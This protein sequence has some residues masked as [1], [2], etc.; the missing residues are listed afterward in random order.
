M[1]DPLATLLAA[2]DAA[3]DAMWIATFKRMHFD[4]L[5]RARNRLAA[6][7]APLDVD[8]L[9][10]ALHLDTHDNPRPYAECP[11]TLN[12]WHVKS[13]AAIAAAYAEETP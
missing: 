2:I 10:R 5:L 9:A 12:G 8:R 1:S 6:T 7:P 3:P 4:D 13:A 11:Q